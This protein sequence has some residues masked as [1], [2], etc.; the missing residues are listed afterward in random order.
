MLKEL[1]SYVNYNWERILGKP[2]SV[3]SE[4][5]KYIDGCQVEICKQYLSNKQKPVVEYQPCPE[6]GST[7]TF[8]Y[9]YWNQMRRKMVKQ[10]WRLECHNCGK[11]TEPNRRKP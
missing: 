6:C 2:E 1:S 3:K 7:N 4:T 8:P 9:Q 5:E 10:N 11:V